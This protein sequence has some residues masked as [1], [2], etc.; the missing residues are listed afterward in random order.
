[1]TKTNK[2]GFIGAVD[3]PVIHAFRIGYIEGAKYANPN[4]KVEYTFITTGN[5]FSGFEKP[6]E[7]FRVATKQYQSGID[8]IFQVAGGQTGNGIINA[9]KTEKKFAI[10]VDYDEDHIAK[11]F[12]L[13]SMI[14]RIDV[15][16]YKEVMKIIN[17]KF[18]SGVVNYGLSDKGVS[19]SPMK[20]TKH[21]IPEEILKKLKDVEKNIIAGKIKVTDY[22]EN[23]SP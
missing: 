6:E 12:V 20:Y 19:L 3:I 5:D 1:M 21:L 17:G 11:G 16:T 14:K 8:I 9:A 7:G 22:L 2:I 13:T 10:G 15:S 23:V 4:I 18:Q